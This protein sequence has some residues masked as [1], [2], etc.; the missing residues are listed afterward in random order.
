MIRSTLEIANALYG[1][2]PPIFWTGPL[3]L[4]PYMLSRVSPQ[5]KIFEF[6]LPLCTTVDPWPKQHKMFFFRNFPTLASRR[7]KILKENLVLFR[8]WIKC[9]TKWK[10]ELRNFV[11]GGHPNAVI[12]SKRLIELHFISRSRG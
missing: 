6:N 1:Q 8:P 10:I 2:I 3:F 12:C 9:G 4:I 7:R 5:N 11:L